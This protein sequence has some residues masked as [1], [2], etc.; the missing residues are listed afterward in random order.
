MYCADKILITL[1]LHLDIKTVLFFSHLL[2]ALNKCG[3]SNFH[4]VL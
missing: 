1:F 3:L 2:T 4:Y